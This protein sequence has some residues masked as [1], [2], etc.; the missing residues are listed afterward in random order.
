[1]FILHSFLVE[2]ET[3]FTLWLNRVAGLFFFCGVI[4]SGV[5]AYQKKHRIVAFLMLGIGFLMILD[6][7]LL[8]F[9]FHKF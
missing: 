7:V 9:W 1:M 8:K 3:S 6:F 4:L 2:P 5:E